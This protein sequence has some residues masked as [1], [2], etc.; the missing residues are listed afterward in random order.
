MSLHLDLEHIFKRM[1]NFVPRKTNVILFEQKYPEQI[2][3]SVILELDPI[4]EAIFLFGVSDC[5]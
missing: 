4:G 1:W 5:G 3:K 2:P